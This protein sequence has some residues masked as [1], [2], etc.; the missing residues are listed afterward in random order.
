MALE[1]LIGSLARS[2][3][4]RDALAGVCLHTAAFSPVP[5]LPRAPPTGGPDGAPCSGNP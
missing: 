3:K 2:G 4:S 5:L 1:G